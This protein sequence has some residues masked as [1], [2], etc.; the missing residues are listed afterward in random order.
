M[1]KIKIFCML[2]FLAFGI[3]VF[4]TSSQFVP[5]VESYSS[6][7][8]PSMTGAPGDENCTFCHDQHAGPGVFFINA[9]LNYVPGQTY[10]IQV[11]HTTT[12]ATRQRWGFELTALDGANTAAGTFTDT[13][14]FTQQDFGNLRYYIEHNQAGSFA[15]TSNGA[16]WSFDWNAPAT[17]IGPVT[18]YAAGN[19]ANNNSSTSE[20]QIYLATT[21]SQPAAPASKQCNKRS[22]WLIVR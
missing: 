10:Q 9:P 14:A 16:S 6:G 20:D 1:N 8:P 17:D 7:P 11:Q 4:F 22:D 3:T 12:D 15:G 13:T 21:V 5:V 2:G 19:Q 18:F